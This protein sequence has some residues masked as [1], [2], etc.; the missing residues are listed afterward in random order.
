MA[1]KPSGSMGKLLEETGIEQV[2]IEGR[3]SNDHN[4]PEEFE[5]LGEKLVQAE[6]GKRKIII[7]MDEAFRHYAQED[8]EQAGLGVGD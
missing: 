7:M 6:Q 8:K 5:A 2:R 1:G 4:V 3:R